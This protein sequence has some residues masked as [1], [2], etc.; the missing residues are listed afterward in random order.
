MECPCCGSD[1]HG[2]ADCQKL[3]PL[4]IPEDVKLQPPNPKQ[5]YGDKKV[6]LGLFPAA[7]IIYGALAF[8]LGAEKYGPYN[9]RDSAVEFMTYAHSSLRHLHAV[10]DGEDIDPESGKPHIGLAIAGLAILADA[11]ET[12]NLI[13]NRPTAGAASR[14]LKTHT[15]KPTT[16]LAEWEFD[17]QPLD[18]AAE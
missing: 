7:G 1:W 9:W 13:D 8:Q 3:Q 4:K 16:P 5:A 15:K 6:P 18:R 17:H 14:L 2:L 11:I 10:I 12:G